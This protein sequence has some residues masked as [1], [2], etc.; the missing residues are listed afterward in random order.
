MVVLVIVVMCIDMV[1]IWLSGHSN[2]PLAT[3]MHRMAGACLPHHECVCFAIEEVCCLHFDRGRMEFA[4]CT[5]L[6]YRMQAEASRYKHSPIMRCSGGKP[7]WTAGHGQRAST[8]Y[9]TCNME[10]ATC[11]FW[12]R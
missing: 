1:V 10:Y 8:G 6:Q 2:V 7:L 5:K 12:Q 3:A 4:S 9:V 11:I